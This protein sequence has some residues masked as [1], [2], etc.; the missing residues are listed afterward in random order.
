MNLSKYQKN[1]PRPPHTIWT[2]PIHFITCGFGVGTFP[3]FP[4]TMGTLASIPL[5]I[6][7]SHTP[8]WFYI[9]ACVALFFIG[10]YLCDIT[11]RDFGTQDHPA[12]VMDEFATFPIVMIA[13]PMQ[14]HFLL[15]GFLLFRFLISRSQVLFAGLIKIFT[16]VSASCSMMWPPQFVL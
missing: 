15:A 11:N 7:L 6:M 2:N 4:G 14:W 13:V 5:T 8:L 16:M 10:S 12:T 1:V 3:W 9:F